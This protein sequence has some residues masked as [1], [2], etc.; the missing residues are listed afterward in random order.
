[1]SKHNWIGGRVL[2]TE[3]SSGTVLLTA[4]ETLMSDYHH[5]EFLGFG[6]CAPS[7]FVP[8]WLY[9]FLFFPSIRTRDG[10]PVAAPY[11]LRKVEAQLLN[12]GFD[13]LTVAPSDLK[14]Y[15]DAA[16]V[17]GI[18]VMDPFGLGPASSTLASVLKREPFLARCFRHMLSRPE[19]REAKSKG[20]SIILG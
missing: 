17:L 10:V 8:D 15:I 13:V 16:Q 18:Y 7:N 12:E 11:G 1:M 6:T 5:N 14:R 2:R 20:L 9:R 4:D 3:S 19:V